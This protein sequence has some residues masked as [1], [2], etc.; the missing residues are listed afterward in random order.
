M[1]V[2]ACVR[3]CVRA[4]VCL[5]LTLY[6][7]E[8]PFLST[9][10]C[11]AIVRSHKRKTE[12]GKYGDDQLGKALRA[13]SEGIPLIKAYMQFVVPARTLRRHRDNAVTSPGT[14]NPGPRTVILG[15]NVDKAL[16][17]HIKEME[18]RMYGLTTLDVRRLGYEIAV[19]TGANNPFNETTK[20]AGK[21]WLC[22]FLARHP[23]LATNKPQATNIGLAHGFY[24]THG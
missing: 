10:F 13:V 5:F 2:C 20:M 22:G 21:D 23:G 7:S 1:C 24:K 9:S 18:H 19:K 6:N 17:E 12:R 11:R 16:Y 4:C 3:A 8:T 15:Y 14:L